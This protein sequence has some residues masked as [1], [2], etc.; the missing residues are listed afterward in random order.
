MLDYKNKAFIRRCFV[1][2][3]YPLVQCNYGSF[4]IFNASGLALPE[5]LFDGPQER[6]TIK[7]KGNDRLDE[8][9]LTRLL[10]QASSAI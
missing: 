5:G 7:I 1:E 8:E 4:A 2:L 10:T 6:K 3:T 9:M